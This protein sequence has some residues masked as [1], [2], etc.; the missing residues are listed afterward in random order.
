MSLIYGSCLQRLFRQC[1]ISLDPLPTLAVIVQQ[2][3]FNVC[4]VLT[5]FG[6]LFI[7]LAMNV[8][9]EDQPFF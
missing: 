9:V 1:T 7:L 6:C 4:L 8:M 2:R 3:Q 5:A